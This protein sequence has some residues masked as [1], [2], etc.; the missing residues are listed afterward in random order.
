MSGRSVSG[1][2]LGTSGTWAGTA[3]APTSAGRS[4]V[5]VAPTFWT[6]STSRILVTKSV[7]VECATIT[8]IASYVA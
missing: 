4:E 3:G 8:P 2:V 1:V 5:R 7:A 6:P